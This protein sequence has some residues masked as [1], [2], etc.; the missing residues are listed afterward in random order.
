MILTELVLENFG[1]YVGKQ[2]IN[3]HPE[4]EAGETR[5]IILFGGM[6]GGGKTTLMDAIRLALYGSRAQCSTRGNL[7]YGDFLS[8]C[9]NRQSPFT[10]KSRLEL[11]FKHIDRNRWVELRIVRYWTKNP[12][13]GKDTLGILEWNES[14]QDY[15]K[16]D[17]LTETWDEYIE[18]LLPLGISNLFLFDGEQVKELAEQEVPP[19]TVVK[20]IES[21]LGLELIERLSIDIDILVKRKQKKLANF[22]QKI[23]LDEIDIKLKKYQAELAE[24][25]AEEATLKTQLEKAEKKAKE[26]SDR[27]LSEGGKIAS[28]EADLERQ[29]ADL[30]GQ[31]E[32]SRQYLRE[33]AAEKLPLALIQPLLIAARTQGERETKRQQ[34]KNAQALVQATGDRL[35]EYIKN[36]KLKADQ[37]K[38]IDQFLADENQQLLDQIGAEKDAWLAADEKA[39]ETLGIVVQSDLG[40][41]IKSAQ[42]TRAEIDQ[43]ELQLNAIEKQLAVAPP[44]EIYEQLK[45]AVQKTQTA[46]IKARINYENAQHLVVQL[47]REINKA[48]KELINYV[49]NTIERQQDEHTIKTAA[50]VQD[51]LKLFREKLT[52]KKLSKLEKEVTDC[53]RYLLH[54]LDLVHRVAIDTKDFSLSLYDLQGEPVPK[55][56]ISAGEKQLLAIAFLW[57]LAR[58]SGRELPVAIDTPLGRLDSEHRQNL[59]ERYFPAASHQ[60]ILLSTDTELGKEEVKKLRKQKAIAREYLL[61]YNG[62]TRQTNIEP[63]YFW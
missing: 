41:R 46:L 28:R 37:I 63:G 8:Q 51:T 11:A 15:W 52:I 40:D 1:P 17:Y 14:Q 9:V 26:A 30:E 7:S 31:I 18:N 49:D 39:L 53:F 21:L 56:R 22:Q 34:A 25:Q 2:I 48:K 13:D 58:V 6:N 43:L 27:F 47:E 20:A 16:D 61:K 36:L 10:D 57:G 5:P 55:H 12:K 33:L 19:S 32:R 42:Q 62:E 60:V 54:K 29:K 44:P 35:L 24:A 50:R 3:F 45:N 4:A 59:I 38:K 23:S